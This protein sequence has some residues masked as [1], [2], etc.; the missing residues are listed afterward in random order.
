MKAGTIFVLAVFTSYAV[1]LGGCETT[2]RSAPP[3]TASFIRAGL[4]ENADARTLAQGRK[5]FL[6]RCIECHALPAVTKFSA[7]RLTA[8][9]AEMSGRA[10]LDSEQHDA[11]LKYVLTVRSHEQ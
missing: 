2:L 6:S 8:I 4:R 10:N 5:L 3:V 11:V 1:L 7:P 9:V